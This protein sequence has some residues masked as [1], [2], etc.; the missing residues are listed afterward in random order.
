MTSINSSSSSN[1]ITK[2]KKRKKKEKKL[3]GSIEPAD[4]LAQSNPADRVGFN[5]PADLLGLIKPSASAG[6]RTQQIPWLNRT[7]Q[8]CWVRLN[9]ADA[10]GSIEPSRC[11]GFDHPADLLGSIEP[12]DLLGSRTQ[13]IYWV[14]EPSRS[15]RFDR[16]QRI[17][18]VLELDSSAGFSNPVMLEVEEETSIQFESG[19]GEGGVLGFVL[20][21]SFAKRGEGDRVDS[22][23]K[24]MAVVMKQLDRTEEAIEAIKSFRGR[25]SEKAQE[26]LDNVLMDLYKKCGKVD[27]QIELLKR[28]LRQIYQGEIFNGKP[29]KTARSHGKKFQVS[30]KQETARLLVW[31]FGVGVHAEIKLLNGRG[32]VPE[33]PNDRSRRQQG[34]QLGTLSDQARPVRGCAF[35]AWRDFARKASG[36]GGLQS[37]ETGGGAVNGG[38]SHA[39]GDGVVGP[40]G[41]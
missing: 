10:L 33:S 18:W 40:Y 34:Q 36:F 3:L 37:K 2:K 16:A 26:S 12:A 19:F 27:E 31:E 5:H 4:L 39:T 22:A 25:C 8:N 35:G 24:D 15:A 28:K 41:P 20:A 30:V 21:V 7:Q 9:P 38:G 17:C 11:V 29:T 13:R 23:L 14:R 1:K 32:G 6:Y